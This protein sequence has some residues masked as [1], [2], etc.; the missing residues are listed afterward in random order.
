M[1]DALGY[2]KI[3]QINYDADA[4]T[5]KHSYRDLAK[6]WHPDYNKDKDTT[7]I[8]QKLSIAYEVLSNNN[9]RLIYDILSLVYTSDNYPDLDNMSLFKYGKET[10]NLRVVNQ[11]NVR[12]WFWSYKSYN[13]MQISDYKRALQLNAKTSVLNWLTGWWHI[14][15]F[16]KNIKAI[17][18]NFSSPISPEESFRILV[19]NM[20][21]YARDNCNL[22]ALKCGILAT[23]FA[24]TEDKKVLERFLNSLNLK[25]PRSKMWNIIW[26]KAVQLIIPFVLVVL[27]L[28]PTVGSYINLS[29]AELWSIFSDKKE[30]DYYQQVNF[31]DGGESVDDVVVGKVLSIPVDKSDNSK[32]YHLTK[33][34]EIMYGPSADFDVIK[35]LPQSTTV[36]LTGYTPDN[37]WARI[38][39]DNGETGFV[40]FENIKQGMGKEIPFGSSIIN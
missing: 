4:N 1:R 21:V 37:V 11:Q 29:E 3:L 18:F 40:Y 31:N 30:I 5:I 36:R 27:F 8:F 2:Y 7:D 17:K 19:H 26:L 6:K 39:L 24:S 14:R 33:T 38:M 9:S 13:D 23:N 32:L 15:A 22:E 35:T 25:A 16:F 12:A 20:I 34:S 10:I 28:F